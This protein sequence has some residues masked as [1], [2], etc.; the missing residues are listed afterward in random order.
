MFA[1]LRKF[2]RRTGTRRRDRR[3]LQGQIRRVLGLSLK[4]GQPIFEPDTTKSWIVY[5][6]V[7]SGKTTCV[8]VPAIQA[9]MADH[10]RCLIVNDVKS[11]EICLQIIDLLIR[12]G[13]K[14]GVID[15]SY[16]LGADYPHRVRLNPFGNLIIA[17]EAKSRT[18]LIEIETVTHILIKEPNDGDEK[19]QFFREGP[20]EFI[21]ISILMI[22]SRNPRLCTP[23]GVAA[24]L[25]DMDVWIK[26][27]EIEAEEG[28]D[29]TRS[30]ARQIK[31]L[32]ENDPEHFSMHYLGAM[33]ALKM[34]QV[35]APMHNA[36]RD[37]ELT[38]AEL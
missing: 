3:K 32:R 5:A 18:L 33:T 17:Y 37:P 23:G 12:S 36:G 27:I 20:R 2:L 15:D 21:V 1:F 19:N 11:A 4:L 30:R 8:A 22:L 31:E 14:V 35:G 13:R 10:D 7:G 9:M 34:F 25:G 29:L 24:F 16:V 38:H 26:A 28:D 6:S